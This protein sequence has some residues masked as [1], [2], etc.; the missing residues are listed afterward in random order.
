MLNILPTNN[1][2][3]KVDKKSMQNREKSFITKWKKDV[4][5][6]RVEKKKNWKKGDFF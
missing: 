4:G 3:L 1:N 5:L 6:P 2:S